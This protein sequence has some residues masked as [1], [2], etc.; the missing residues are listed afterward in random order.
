MSSVRSRS[1]IE[2]GGDFI[3]VASIS[4][5]DK[6]REFG[7]AKVIE[8]FCA[9]VASLVFNSVAGFGPVVDIIEVFVLFE[10]VDSSKEDCETV[11]VAIQF[12]K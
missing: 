12:R 7:F 3:C 1:R 4:V 8:H 10:S 11:D 2:H 9:D 5:V 6:R